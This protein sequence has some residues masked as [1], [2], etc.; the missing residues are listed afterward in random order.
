MTIQSESERSWLVDSSSACRLRFL[1]PRLVGAFWF[2]SKRIMWTHSSIACFDKPK[3]LIEDAI[4]KPGCLE[5]FH[6]FCY[7][8]KVLS[9]PGNNSEDELIYLSG[10]RYKRRF[11]NWTE[12][13]YDLE[14]GGSKRKAIVNWIIKGN[15]HVWEAIRC[16]NNIWCWLKNVIGIII[17]TAIIISCT[18][19]PI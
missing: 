2:L 12:N 18:G 13:G 9:W 16:I 4:K 11:F 14:I 17:T 3:K 19:T 10:V 15:N 7:S 5:D 6:P 8:N 1:P